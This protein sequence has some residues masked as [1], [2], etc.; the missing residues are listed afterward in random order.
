MSQGFHQE[1]RKCSYYP[2]H[3][4]SQI[5]SEALKT[6]SFLSMYFIHWVKDISNFPSSY[7]NTIKGKVVG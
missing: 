3:V 6:I 5:W 1:V 7:C 4:V 2:S